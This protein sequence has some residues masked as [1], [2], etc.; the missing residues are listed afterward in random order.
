[1]LYGEVFAGEIDPPCGV[2]GHPPCITGKGSIQPIIYFN[3][4]IFHMT[5]RL[6]NPHVL[7]FMLVLM[8]LHSV[9]R[10]ANFNSFFFP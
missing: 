7:F 5:S 2:E 4:I 8:L 6:I 10:I 9:T 3:F 1:M